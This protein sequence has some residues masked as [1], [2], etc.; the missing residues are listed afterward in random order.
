V[1]SFWYRLDFLMLF[2]RVHDFRGLRKELRF[3]SVVLV[4]QM[5]VNI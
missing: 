5:S 3:I 4:V 1:F 2:E